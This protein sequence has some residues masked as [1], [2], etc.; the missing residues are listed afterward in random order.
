MIRNL[1]SFLLATNKIFPAIEIIKKFKRHFSFYKSIN[2]SHTNVN[3]LLNTIEL[4]HVMLIIY[5]LVTNQP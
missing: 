4:F 3:G 5:H 2:I 1:K